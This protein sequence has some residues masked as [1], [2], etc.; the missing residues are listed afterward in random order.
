MEI[1]S[2]NQK[3]IVGILFINFNENI[4]R[5]HAYLLSFSSPHPKRTWIPKPPP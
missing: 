2:H 1:E 3:Q 5:L 4:E